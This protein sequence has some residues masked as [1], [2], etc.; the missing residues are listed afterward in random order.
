[1]HLARVAG[2]AVMGLFLDELV[3]LGLVPIE[4]A[5][6]GEFRHQLVEPAV[7]AGTDV[8]PVHDK[9]PHDHRKTEAENDPEPA[10]A[11]S[12]GH[13][14]Q[15]HHHQDGRDR[16]ESHSIHHPLKVR[17]NRDRFES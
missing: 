5:G 14:R 1:M 12:F 15:E 8:P 17:P 11:E 9:R 7:G 3:L 13:A 10:S 6:T 2:S 16:T 4:L